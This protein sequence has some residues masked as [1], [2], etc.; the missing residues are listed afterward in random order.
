MRTT[1]PGIA[2]LF[3]LILLKLCSCS[4]KDETILAMNCVMSDSHSC[5]PIDTLLP[6]LS[7]IRPVASEIFDIFVVMGQSNTLVGLGYDSILDH[8]HPRIFQFGRYQENDLKVISS[9]D[10]LEN[11][12][13]IE[14]N[15][16]FAMTFSKWYVHEFL[17]SDRNLMIIP[18]GKGGSGF[19]DGNWNRGNDLYADAVMRINY[20][21]KNYPGSEIKAILWHQGEDDVD[22][23]SYQSALDSMI[24]NL[25]KDCKTNYVIPFIL[26]GMVP[27]WVDQSEN[28]K[29]LE[30][31][32]KDT[33]NRISQCSFADPREPC[34]ISKKH[35]EIDD[36]HYDAMGQR[37]LGV[38]YF[39]AYKNLLP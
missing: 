7:E 19:G 34:R 24:V 13:V 31:I 4:H 39:E 21:L 15:V 36:I 8:G 9:Q 3:L 5:S 38:R 18:C 6:D 20:V 12:D 30:C 14:N 23:S 35:D 25:R 16:G 29:I 17:L 22:N 27:F 26:G 2:A 11:H 37:I 1:T 33:P 32:I 10:P 28:R